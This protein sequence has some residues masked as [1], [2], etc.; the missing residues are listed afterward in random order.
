MP[1][2]LGYAPCCCSRRPPWCR[3]GPVL[4]SSPRPPHL[5][6]AGSPL[7]ETDLPQ[8]RSGAI[9][10]LRLQ[11]RQS[12]RHRRVRPHP[13]LRP[14]FL[15]TRIG[16]RTT[17]T[18]CCAPCTPNH[19]S[20]VLSWGVLHR[21]LHTEVDKSSAK[22]HFS[23]PRGT[24]FRPLTAAH[25]RDACP[26]RIWCQHSLQMS[27]SVTRGLRR[28]QFQG[29]LG[30]RLAYRSTTNAPTTVEVTAVAAGTNVETRKCW[31]CPRGPQVRKGDR[32]A[33]RQ[34][35]Q[36]QGT[37][38]SREGTAA[39]PGQAGLS[40]PLPAFHVRGVQCPL[41]P[42]PHLCYQLRDGPGSRLPR[43]FHGEGRSGPR[44]LARSPRVPKT[45]RPVTRQVSACHLHAPWHNGFTPHRGKPGPP[46]AFSTPL[47]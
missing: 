4:D 39:W 3:S 22:T 41:P 45:H 32:R 37:R 18:P 6:E 2:R 33:N 16:I 8:P 19:S 40:H 26:K 47:I 44:A 14:G 21:P 17:R 25:P 35:R 42:A 24:C 11:A 38:M 46:T 9:R 31:Q 7:R 12:Q 43:V 23:C 13:S 15:R 10:T 29:Q 30:P 20:P 34:D 1:A 5:Q 36:G 27:C 28:T